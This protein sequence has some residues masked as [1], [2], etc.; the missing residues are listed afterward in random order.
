[1]WDQ[2]LISSLT[3][4]Y[5]QWFTLIADYKVRYFYQI[6]GDPSKLPR[7]IVPSDN[8]NV[9][10]KVDVPIFANMDKEA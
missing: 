2:I 9:R 4:L 10:T 8:E 1:M 6:G 3:F 5:R 7:L